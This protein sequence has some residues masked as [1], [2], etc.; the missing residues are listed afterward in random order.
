[1]SP[2][3]AIRVNYW[4]EIEYEFIPEQRCLLATLSQLVDDSCHYVRTRHFPR[5]NSGPNYK[6]FLL[7]QKLLRLI[8][9]RKEVFVLKL[10][11][12]I[13]DALFGSNGNKLY[14][15]ALQRMDNIGSFEI[16]VGIGLAFLL[17][18]L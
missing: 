1:M 13:G 9:H 10:L 15:S 3:H 11:S 7:R 18:G 16:D 4:E 12:F 14:W 6:H 8:L 5:V 2:G 17:N